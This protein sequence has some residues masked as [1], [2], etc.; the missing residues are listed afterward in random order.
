MAKLITIVGATGAQGK[1]VVSAFINNPAYKV[2]AIT[3]NPSSASG[4][5]L[6]AQGAEVV[7][8]DL[9]DVESL[10]AAFAGSHI[11]Y[12]VTNFFEPFITHQSP[13]KA[14]D[15]ELEQGI[16]LA[17]AAAATPT[18]EH[19]IWSTLPN[20][21][22]LTGGKY[23]VPHLDAKCRVDAHIRAHLPE[24]LAKST[25]L[26]VTWYHANYHVPVY[27][28]LWI[29]AA[30]KYIQLGSYAPETP[31]QT[32]GDVSANV[33][34]FVKA[35]VERGDETK[36][37]AVVLAAAESYTAESMLQL[38]AKLRGKEAQ[39]VRVSEQAY[40]DL[41]PV[42]GEE[43][44]L[45]MEFWNLCCERTWT[46]EDGGKLFTKDDL[47]VTGFKTLEQSFKEEL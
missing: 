40:R 13:T 17:L 11:I 18:L 34:L 46:R 24:L 14:M 35:A 36:N 31:I 20:S 28:P 33:G 39:F 29:P 47:G 2:R 37:G 8:A 21:A 25:F 12:G 26:W 44:G 1:G 5:A 4:Q 7:A 9:N 23:L 42:W 3:R 43:M 45:M 15:I 41:W 38:W 30:N 16:N 32:I 27:A 10:K 6:A 19:Y 22:S